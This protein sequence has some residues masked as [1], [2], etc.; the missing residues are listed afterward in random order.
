MLRKVP[1]DKNKQS[2]D[3]FKFYCEHCGSTISFYS[4]EREKKICR[5]CGRY[6][7]K[8]DR[9]KFKD[10]LTKKKKEAEL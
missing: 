7:Y 9:A 1:G 6:N 4:F 10:I 3:N 2:K 5:V 8:N